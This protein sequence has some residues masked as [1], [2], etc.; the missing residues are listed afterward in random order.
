M[1]AGSDA[2]LERLLDSM[3]TEELVLLTAGADVWHTAAIE[4][5]GIPRMRV[6]DGPVGVRGT[7]FDGEASINAPCSTALA[8]TW[9]IDAVEQI[10]QM[11]SRELV[12]KGA[13]VLLAPTVNIHR[14]PVGGRNF[15]CMSEDAYLT[16]RMAV[17][18]VR[19]VQHDGLACCIKHFVAN[20]TEFE[21]MSIDARIDER[22]LREVYLR[23]FEDAVHDAG[24]KAVMTAYNRIDGVFA[25]DSPLIADVLRG[26]WGFEGTVISDWFGLHSTAD[27]IRSGLDLEMPG[28]TLHRGRKLLDAIERGEVSVDEVRARAR[29]V[30]WL[31]D[32]T[33]ALGGPGPGPETARRDAADEALVR[34]VGAQGMVLLR[35]GAASQGGTVLP[36]TADVLA[37]RGIRRVAVIGPNAAR[38]ELRGGGSAQVT[39]TAESHPLEAMTAAFGAHGIEVS[40]AQGCQIHRRL[41]ELDLSLTSGLECDIFEHPEQLDDPSLAPLST[42]TKRSARIYWFTDPT[43]RGDGDPEFGARLRTTFTPDVTGTWTFGVESVSPARITIDGAVLLD[44]TDAPKGGSFFGTGRSEITATIDL[45]AGHEYRLEAEVRHR[46]LGLGLGGINLGALAPVTGDLVEAAID[47]AATCDLSI[48]IVGTNDNWESEGWDRADIALPGRQDELITR[49]AQ[50]SK[51]TVVV[52]NAGSPVG[53]PWLDTVD[54]V[55]MAWFPGQ[56][57]G[58]SLVDVLTGAVEPQGRLPVTFPM[59]MED[60]PASEH[61]PG[62]NGVAR[63]L[64]GRLVGHHW[65][66]SIGRDPLFPFGFGL[67]YS[68]VS[69]DSAEAPS[70]FG[71]DVTVSNAG[72]RDAVEVVQVYAHLIDREG[73]DRDEPEQRLV[74]FAKVRV[75]A[76]ATVAARVTLDRHAYRTWDIA[77]SGWTYRTGAHELRVGRSSVDIVHRVMVQP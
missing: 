59:R 29:Q 28:P 63:Y 7:R 11:L 17:A 37:A 41:P 52:V 20:D 27:G 40:Y 57:M 26:E 22:T 74:G 3:T 54:S 18:Y 53:M 58:D 46:R 45:V 36:L 5:L 55:L 76:G 62:R 73:L 31:L 6:S 72:S 1:T 14:T 43:R 68:C 44:N 33:G 70:A 69:I 8:A 4:R 39:P 65:Y 34:R 75:P 13:H 50:V 71:V 66:T 49:V 35:N 21:R 56:A 30:L 61:H 15:E 25:A 77:T 64:E 32:R 38:G 19:G 47:L 16:A 2:H 60:T 48:V 42:S 51:A 9:D 10:G 23:P 24:V 67:G 12:A